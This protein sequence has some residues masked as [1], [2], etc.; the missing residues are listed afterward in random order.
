MQLAEL[1]PD[2]NPCSLFSWRTEALQGE[3]IRIIFLAPSEF[4]KLKLCFFRGWNP[5][6]P[7]L[8]YFIRLYLLV[9][10]HQE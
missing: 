9:A 8:T 4:T 1:F 5:P 6:L 3:A 10:Q 2:S 7:Y